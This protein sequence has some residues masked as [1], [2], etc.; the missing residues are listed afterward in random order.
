MDPRLA[1][2]AIFAVVRGANRSIEDAK[3]WALAQAERS[4]D[5]DARRRLDTLLRDL[6]ESLRLIAEALRPLLPETAERIAA[7]LGLSLSPGWAQALRWGAL[8]SGARVK[9]PEPL[10]PRPPASGGSRR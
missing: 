4:G 10:F 6:A 7:Q 3:P 5:A 9:T 2:D 8:P 1:L